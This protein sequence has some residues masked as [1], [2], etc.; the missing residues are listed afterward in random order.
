MS[1]TTF[2]PSESLREY[3][4]HRFF[5][6]PRSAV[7]QAWVN[8]YQLAQWW[9]PEGF[10]NSVCTLDVRPGGA[11]RIDMRS[12]EGVIYP[13]G[14]TYR[15]IETPARLVFVSAVRDQNGRSLFEVL[16]TA[17]FI[18]AEG[19]TAFNIEVRVFNVAPGAA[20]HLTG[21]NEGWNQSLNR[22]ASFL[23]SFN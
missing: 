14:G 7:F 22:L 20:Q 6:A 8:P 13:M 16:N 1:Q 19:E 4:F 23:S 11:I 18:E 10:T 9:G 17:T 15:E 12:P 2:T 5:D 3:T 21:M